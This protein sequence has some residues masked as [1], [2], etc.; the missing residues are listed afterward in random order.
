MAKGGK[1]KTLLKREEIAEHFGVVPGTITRWER[2]GCPV[3]KKQTRGRHT[4]FDLDAVIE[5]NAL[6]ER[7]GLSLELERAKLTVLQQQKLD[8]ELAIRRGELL[9]RD[10]V[11]AE[12]Q[13]LM[14]A[15][16]S[17]IRGLPRRLSQAGFISRELEASVAQ[18]CVDLLTEISRWE[19]MGDLKK[20]A[21]ESDAA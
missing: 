11:L 9:P 13:G 15:L 21:R 8:I 18:I 4:F 2:D 12:G 16:A 3:A 10:L 17:K 7:S 20:A 19:T 14:K 6:R 5:W 1:R